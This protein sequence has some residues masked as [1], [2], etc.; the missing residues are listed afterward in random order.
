MFSRFSHSVAGSR[1][2][3]L[4]K[5][6]QYSTAGNR[7][8]S[9]YPFTCC[10]A[11]ASWLS[12]IM[13]LGMWVC[14]YVFNSLLS[15]LWANTRCEIAGSCGIFNFWGPSKMFSVAVAPVY[16][17]IN[18]ACKAFQLLHIL[19]NTCYFLGLLFIFLIVTI[20]VSMRYYLVCVWNWDPVSREGV[21]E[22][23][24]L[25]QDL[26]EVKE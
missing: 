6:E 20:L 22:L 8:H 5:A 2:V 21:T 7:S 17:P 15:G 14:M 16:S 18:S 13:L 10:V 3:F 9:V 24:D 19:D 12:W 11:S 1:S 4:F 23:V 26:E 25:S